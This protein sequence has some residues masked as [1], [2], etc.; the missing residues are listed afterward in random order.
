MG[1]KRGFGEPLLTTLVHVLAKLA[2]QFA[3]GVQQLMILEGILRVAD[4][5]AAC[6]TLEQV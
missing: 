1:G 6:L 2:G 4:H 3:L 5:L